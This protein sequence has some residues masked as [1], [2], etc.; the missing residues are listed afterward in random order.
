MLLTTSNPNM[1][2]QLTETMLFMAGT[3]FGCHI[4]IAANEKFM[5]V[6]IRAPTKSCLIGK[7]GWRLETGDFSCTPNPFTMTSHPL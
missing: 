3:D 7:S 5:D 4:F 1:R 2:S 6:F